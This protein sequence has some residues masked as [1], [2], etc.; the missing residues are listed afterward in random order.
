MFSIGKML[1]A[2]LSV[3]VRSSCVSSSP[4]AEF[5]IRA[6]AQIKGRSFQIF[7]SF[8]KIVIFPAG[9]TADLLQLSPG[10]SEHIVFVTESSIG[11]LAIC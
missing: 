8:R 11:R 4:P 6:S 2:V 3:L 10:G 1:R 5:P 7:R 9:Q